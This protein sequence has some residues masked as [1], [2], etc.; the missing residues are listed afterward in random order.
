[1]SHSYSI[2]PV[3]RTIDL[4]I[5]NFLIIIWLGLLVFGIFT[6]IQPKW[7]VDASVLGRESEALDLKKQGDDFM[8]EGNYSAAV[9]RYEVALE[10]DSEL[11]TALGNMA[12]AYAKMGKL[13]Q[14]E[15]TISQLVKKIPER[16]WVGYINL[17]DIFLGRQEYS[18]AREY[19]KKS[20]ESSPFPGNAY[21]FAGYCSMKLDETDKALEYYNLTLKNKTDF[22]L[23]YKGSLRRDHFNYAGD[24]ETVNEIEEQLLLGK[25]DQV[26]ANYDETIFM[27]TVSRDHNIAKIYNDVGIIYYNNSNFAHAEKFFLQALKIDP[28]LTT[29]RQNLARTQVNQ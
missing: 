19:Y 1:M 16:A 8:N 10:T 28:T 17:G 3:D 24:E 29:A 25:Y 15:L 13:S 11:Q 5:R 26:I 14:A 7:L 12:I 9:N 23:L 20:I 4:G 18:K 2:T 27:Q 6:L 21:M 22:E